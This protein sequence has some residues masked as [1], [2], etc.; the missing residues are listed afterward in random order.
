MAFWLYM[1]IKSGYVPNRAMPRLQH[2][3]PE[4]HSRTRTPLHYHCQLEV[5]IWHRLK[6]FRAYLKCRHDVRT[7]PQMITALCRKWAAIPKNDTRTIIGSMRALPVCRL[8]DVIPLLKHSVTFENDP[9]PV[10]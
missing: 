1:C 9:C 4:T 8:T 6:N 3:Y 2:A 7:H 10:I 5:L